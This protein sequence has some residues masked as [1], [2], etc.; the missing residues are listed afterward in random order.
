MIHPRT[1]TASIL[2]VA[3]FSS[4][5]TAQDLSK[6]RDFQFGTRL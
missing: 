1:F 4:L 5:A 2:F 3:L 6:Y